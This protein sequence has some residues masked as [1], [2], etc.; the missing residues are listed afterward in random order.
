MEYVFQ[1]DEFAVEVAVFG[2]AIHFVGDVVAEHVH[3]LAAH[4]F[5][6]VL[7]KTAYLTR[8]R[9]PSDL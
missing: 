3:L 6:C 4:S 5:R 8:L 9:L 2:V 7:I 1:T